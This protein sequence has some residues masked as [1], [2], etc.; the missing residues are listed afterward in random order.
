MPAP[1]R[2]PRY[3][4]HDGFRMPMGFPVEG[5]GSGLRYRPRASDVFVCTYPKCGT[6]WMQYIVFLI[7]SRGQPLGPGQRLD[8]VFPHLEE[9]GAGPVEKLP[10]PRLIKTHLPFSMVPYDAAARYIYVA[11]NP[12]DCAVSFFH[13]TRGFV[14]HYDFA[15]GT[16]DD[17]FECF[18]AGEVDFGDYFEHLL[19]WYA[20]KDDSNVLFVTYERMQ[21]ETEAVIREVGEFL[22]GAARDVVRDSRLVAAVLEESSFRSMSREQRRWSSA[23]APGAPEFVR[24]GIVGDWRNHFS[25]EQARRLADEFARRTGGKG[26]YELWPDVVREALNTF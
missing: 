16:F 24:K 8:Q 17:F 5:F 1:V 11:R 3:V 19:S 25:A 15:D 18:I 12:F 7:R 22:G 10:E 13:H 4:V 21:E 20:R 9:V 23:R 2:R 14:Q 26:A 6:T